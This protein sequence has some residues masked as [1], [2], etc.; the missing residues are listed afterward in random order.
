MEVPRKEIPG[1]LYV[2]STLPSGIFVLQ[3]TSLRRRWITS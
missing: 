1:V 2:V 3:Q